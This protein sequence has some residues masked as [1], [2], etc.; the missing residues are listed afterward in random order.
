MK[1]IKIDFHVH[2]VYS[3]DAYNK[4]EEIVKFCKIKNIDGVV[5]VDNSIEAVNKIKNK[6]ICIPGCEIKT[7]YGEVLGVFINKPVKKTDFLDVIDEIKKMD[8]LIG[9]PHPFDFF[10]K[11]SVRMNTLKIFKKIDFIEVFNSRCIIN[12]FNKIAKNFCERTRTPIVAGSDAH[13]PVEIGNAY[14]VFNETNIEMMRKEI[15]KNKISVSGKISPP[16]VHLFTIRKKY[17]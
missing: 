4:L 17:L 14:T 8:G 2:S 13:L 11:Y 12:K 5:L 16:Y 9:L 1:N 7:E 6:I 3:S 15:L 10:R